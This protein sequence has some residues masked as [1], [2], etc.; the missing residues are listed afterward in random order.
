MD[1]QPEPQG[2]HELLYVH[3]WGHLN[4]L[5]IPSGALSCVNAAR[6]RK[7]GRYAFEVGDDEIRAARVIA[8]DVHWA[9]A[10]TGFGPLVRFVRSVAP[11]VPIVVGGITAGHVA[12]EALEEHA[13]DF[14]VRGT[15]RPA[16]PAS[17]RPCVQAERPGPSPTCSREGTSPRRSHG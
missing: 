9:L 12:R 16:S 17:S 2:D 13:V 10:L 3:P 8:I 5:V 6:V 7:V 4:N 15:P 1:A 14:V 11:R